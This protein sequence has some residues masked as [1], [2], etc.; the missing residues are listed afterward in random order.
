LI[1]Y[2]AIASDIHIR[3]PEASTEIA[4]LAT[5]GEFRGNLDIRFFPIRHDERL[6]ARVTGLVFV[7]ELS[8]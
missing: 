1:V 7:L 5:F 2:V 3:F 4:L 8:R 6:N